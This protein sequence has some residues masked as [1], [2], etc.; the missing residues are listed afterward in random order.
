MGTGCRGLMYRIR[1]SDFD[2]VVIDQCFDTKTDK[3]KQ[4]NAED[5]SR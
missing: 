1:R 4:H 3:A 5:D 2:L